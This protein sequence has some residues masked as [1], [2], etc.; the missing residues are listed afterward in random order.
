MDSDLI[1]VLYGI[2]EINGKDKN[3]TEPSYEEYKNK[4]DTSQKILKE[5]NLSRVLLEGFDPSVLSVFPH[6]QSLY[7]TNTGLRTVRGKGFQDLTSLRLL[8]LRGCPVT[9]FPGKVFFGLKQLEEVYSD[10]YRLCCASVLPEGFNVR[11]C[12]APSDEVSSCES[13]LKSNTYRVLLALITSFALLGNV[14]S[15]VYRLGINRTV[16]RQGFGVLVT[17]LCVSDGLMGVFMAVIGAADQMYMGNYVWRDTEWRRSPVCQL[18]GLIALLSSE[19]S[20]F[21]VCLVTLDRFL[22]IR[23]PF[24]KLRFGPTSG[25]VVGAV[26]WVFGLCLAGV[27]LLPVTS[28]WKFYGQ[29]GICVPL[30]I[31]RVHFPG[32]SYAFGVM[33]VLNSVLFVLLVIGNVF[34]YRSIQQHKMDVAESSGTSKDVTIARRL[35]TVVMSDF[36]CWFPICLLG[37]LAE[38]DFPVSGEVNVAMAIIVLPI[39]SALN[40]FL[41]TFNILKERRRRAQEK[42]MMQWLSRQNAVKS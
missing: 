35:L 4:K 12:R 13:L 5:L 16:N 18:A 8:D 26:A 6:L 42:R 33:I 25:H 19:V 11:Q 7:L 29:A 15:L 39:N 17:H 34:I 3:G 32:K 9:S 37:L 30:P 14:A 23:F 1:R 10:T 22:A 24:R 27:P 28:H 2:A 20:T 21:L 41:Y 38:G 31:T 36:V 40:P